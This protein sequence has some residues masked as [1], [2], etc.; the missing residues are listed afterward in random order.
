MDHVLW[1]PIDFAAFISL[2]FQAFALAKSNHSLQGIGHFSKQHYKPSP[3]CHPPWPEAARLPTP[4]EA[5]AG[6]TAAI[7]THTRAK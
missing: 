2:R 3:Q 4:A 5:N 7:I 6:R 1:G